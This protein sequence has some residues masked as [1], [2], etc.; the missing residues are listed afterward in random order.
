MAT[1][2]SPPPCHF[3]FPLA[4]IFYLPIPHFKVGQKSSKQ[5]PARILLQT[6]RT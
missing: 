5:S 3:F 4:S 2:P 1:T 6:C